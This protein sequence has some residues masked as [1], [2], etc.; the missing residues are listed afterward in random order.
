[1]S[2]SEGINTTLLK[3]LNVVDQAGSGVD[4]D[5]GAGK[6][7]DCARGRVQPVFDNTKLKV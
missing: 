2:G 5:A 7:A 4:H 6:G 1:M 3:M